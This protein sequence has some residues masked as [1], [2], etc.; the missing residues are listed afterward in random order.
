MPASGSNPFCGCLVQE[1]LV[2][3]SHSHEIVLSVF[4]GRWFDLLVQVS[5]RALCCEAAAV[6][7]SGTG[8]YTSLQP[9]CL[10][11]SDV[12]KPDTA[13]RLGLHNLSP[14]HQMRTVLQHPLP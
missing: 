4:T 1:A 10:Q 6:E 8:G 12:S 5:R 14:S 2:A 7:Y 3:R 9:C 13:D 11:Q